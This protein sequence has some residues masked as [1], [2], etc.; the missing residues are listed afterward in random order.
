MTYTPNFVKEITRRT[1]LN[2]DY[3]Q[4]SKSNNPE[5]EVFEVT[6]LLNS[7][8]AV[9]VLSHAKEFA[10]PDIKAKEL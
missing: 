4:K 5:Q 2:L 1:I 7:L 9:V 6:Q 8:Y 3:I 10:F